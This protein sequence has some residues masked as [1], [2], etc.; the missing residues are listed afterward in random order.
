M[1]LKV[2]MT[3]KVQLTKVSHKSQT[4][5]HTIDFVKWHIYTKYNSQ[6]EPMYHRKSLKSTLSLKV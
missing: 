2:S 3:I 5:L 1:L 4:H 6:P